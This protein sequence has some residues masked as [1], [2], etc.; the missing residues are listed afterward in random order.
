MV[1]WHIN[2]CTGGNL[3][4]SF[5]AIFL[6]HP[7]WRF[8][9]IPPSDEWGPFPAGGRFHF[10][11]SFQT[12]PLLAGNGLLGPVH[13]ISGLLIASGQLVEPVVNF[14]SVHGMTSVAVHMNFSLLRGNFERRVTRCT[15]PG[16]RPF[17]G[18]FFPCEQNAKV[19]LG[20]AQ[21]CACSLLMFR[22]NFPI[23]KQFQKAPKIAKRIQMTMSLPWG[24][25]VVARDNKSSSECEVTLNLGQW[26]P[27]G[28]LLSWVH[29][30]R[31]SVIQKVKLLNMNS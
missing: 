11:L 15:T 16:N 2:V 14:A 9:L 21:S 1:K 6:K 5:L 7:V 17:Q 13:I 26:L 18:N 29:V 25:E 23:N 19:A 12:S 10:L 31:R 8:V 28:S 22:I 30:N 3:C 24:N 20:Q 27:R 4:S